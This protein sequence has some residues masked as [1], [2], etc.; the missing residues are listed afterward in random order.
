MVISLWFN[1]LQTKHLLRSAM[2]ARFVSFCGV[3]DQQWPVLCSDLFVNIW[4][5]NPLFEKTALE[6]VTKLPLIVFWVV[7]V[8]P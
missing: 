8:W 3:Y 7:K 1:E 6:Q 5:Q 2:L 4:P